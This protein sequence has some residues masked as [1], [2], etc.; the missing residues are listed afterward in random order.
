VVPPCFDQPS[1]AEQS[2]LKLRANGRTR[3]KDSQATFNAP[4]PGKAFSQPTFP[5]L[6]GSRQ[7]LLL[8]VLY[9]IVLDIL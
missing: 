5:L 3:G 8:N 4:V 2:I 7:Y 6:A 9:A 1:H